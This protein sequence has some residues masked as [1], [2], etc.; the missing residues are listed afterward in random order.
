MNAWCVKCGSTRKSSLHAGRQR[1]AG[2][3]RALTDLELKLKGIGAQCQRQSN[4]GQTGTRGHFFKLINV[5]GAPAVRAPS[6]AARGL[7]IEKSLHLS[8]SFPTL[9]D[10][11]QDFI[12]VSIINALPQRE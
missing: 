9:Q 3:S 4:S 10:I 7:Q 2:F 5:A 11:E 12:N 6:G 8:D 1:L